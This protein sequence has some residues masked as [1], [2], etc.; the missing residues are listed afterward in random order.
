MRVG[1]VKVGRSTREH[2]PGRPRRE[3]KWE[4]SVC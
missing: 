2:S 4:D 1:T 3:R